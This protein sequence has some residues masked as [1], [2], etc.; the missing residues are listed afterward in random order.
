M[1]VKVC[2]CY[3][4]E[5][6]KTAL[7]GFVID[8]KVALDAGSLAR[9][10]TLKQQQSIEHILITHT[11][12]DHIKDLAFI[13]DNV[14]GTVSKPIQIWGI[15]STIDV[16]RNHL[17]NDRIW[18]DFSKLPTAENPTIQFN[19]IQEEKPFKVG[20]YT[21]LAVPTKHPVPNTGYLVTNDEGTFCF[22]GD[23]GVTTRLWEVINQQKKMLGLITEVS[24]PNE[25]EWLAEV[26]GHL[27]PKLLKQQIDQLKNRKYT[28]FLSHMKPNFIDLLKKEVK[29]EKITDYRFLEMG[30]VIELS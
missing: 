21:C 10:L 2:G 20:E 13:A 17:M 22:S 11:H 28:V 5:T 18:P 29:A 15:K 14:I 6:S 16:I 8:G 27:T 23:T 19:V 26:S 1:R 24:F 25:Q 12:L 9:S 30:E 4:G 7:T 3:G